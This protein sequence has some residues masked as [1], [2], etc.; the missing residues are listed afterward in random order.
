[1]LNDKR[2]TW[3][4][5]Y[6]LALLLVALIIPMSVQAQPTFVNAANPAL[7]AVAHG[8]PM[9]GAL[10]VFDLEL[11]QYGT[12]TLYLV[13]FPV[14]APDAT[15]EVVGGSSVPAPADAYFR[16]WA[17]NDP[18]TVVMFAVPK[19]GK[20]KMRGVITGASGTWLLEGKPGAAGLKTRRVDLERELAGRTFECGADKLKKTAASM[21]AELAE[22]GVVAAAGIPVNVLY[23]G[24]MIIDTDYEYW[25]QFW[26]QFSGTTDGTV[27]AQQASAAAVQYLGDLLAYASTAYERDVNTNLI[28]QS[29]RLFADNTDPYSANSNACGCTGSGKLDEVQSVWSGNATPRTLVHFISGKSEG[30]GCA[31]IGVLCSQGSGYGASS[32]IGTG[33]NIDN[34][35]FMWEGMVIAHEIGHNFNSPH[36]QGYCN[37][38]GNPNPVDT[39]AD[40]EDACTFTDNDLPGFGSL[41]GGQTS[42]HPGTIMSYCHQLTGSYA[43]IAH[44]FGLTHPYGIAAWRVPNRMLAH[45]QGSTACMALAYVGSDLRLVKDCKP[46]DPM[47]AGETATCTITVENLGPDTAQ[48]AVMIDSYLS[49]G[50]FSIG[51][52]TATKGSTPMPA[53]TCTKTA[54]P[55]N[56]SGSVTCDLDLIDVGHK[57]VIQIPVSAATP[58]NINDRAQVTSDTHDPDMT[59][60]EA[61]DTVT[62]IE[63]ADL[64]ITKSAPGT[65]IAGNTLTYSLQVTNGGPSTATNVVIEDVVP[66][67][68]AINSVSAASGTCNAGVPGNAALPTTCTFDSLASG[69][70]RTMTIVVT[71][72]PQTT[73]ILGNNAKVKSDTYDPNNSNNLDTVA[74][75]VESH[76]DLVVTKSDYP[77]PVLAGRILTYEVVISN[78]GPSTAAGVQL[79]DNLPQ[80]VAFQGYTISGG[81]G[82]CSLLPVPPN[83]LSCDLNN[84]NPAE[85]VRVIFT[86]L[87]QPSVPNA[88]Q[89]INTATASS[90]AFDPNAAN[91]TSQATTT[92][93]TQADMKIA[94]SA[95]VPTTNPSASIVYTVVVANDGPS[96]ALNVVMVD[97]LPLD[98]KKVI[99]VTDSSNGACSYSNVAPHS[100]TCNY[101]TMAPGSSR[102]V[103]I[104][105]DAKGSVGTITNVATVSTTTTDP[106]LAN[107][108]V[109]NSILVKGGKN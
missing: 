42:D 6:S 64:S 99:Y 95:Q 32:S 28:I 106:N 51:N 58:Q 9:G 53:T 60:N 65:V 31:Y 29:A 98:P 13:R 25:L 93:N 55:Q 5:Y 3:L 20:G 80:E 45:V 77:D 92:V 23:T 7:P 66:A 17:A 36:T 37:I 71:V 67:G 96:D 14:F 18:K 89:L 103:D 15:I 19:K 4:L 86:V 102:S 68:V 34:P 52:V 72:A 84:L 46:D 10:R 1:M 54:N 44:T 30:C 76:A 75:T 104:V 87:V 49:N 24:H 108:T 8:V 48:G 97:T 109:Q 41:T 70:S 62:V 38:Y 83:T 74:T 35:G 43:N 40:G 94:K 33:F 107:N 12:T 78:S 69:A 27:R 11:D 59:N 73:G 100:V 63:A 47:L 81:T 22:G 90:S 21:A 50:T 26:N 79:T 82:A 39:C 61:T 57:V 56:G 105:V 2:K 88:S 16:G 101:G 91:S 85:F